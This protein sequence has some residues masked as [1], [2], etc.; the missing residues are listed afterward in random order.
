MDK[1]LLQTLD[2]GLQNFAA[3]SWHRFCLIRPQLKKVK[4]PQIVLNNRLWRTA[5]LCYQDLAIVELGSKFFFHSVEY[6][7]QML[8]QILPHELAHYAD[9]VLYGDSDDAKGHGT[10]WTNLM[11]DYGLDADIYH[12]MDLKA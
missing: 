4:Q 2:Q 9:F 11:L 8:W 5:G 3:A 12:T 7:Q 1:K 6:T 10:Q